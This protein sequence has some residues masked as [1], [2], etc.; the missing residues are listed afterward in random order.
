MVPIAFLLKI[1]VIVIG[2][3]QQLTF[4]VLAAVNLLLNGDNDIARMVG[5]AFHTV[6]LKTIGNLMNDICYL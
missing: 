5:E 1:W 6:L 3:R 2:R 4:T